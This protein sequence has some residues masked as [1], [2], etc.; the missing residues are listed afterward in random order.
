MGSPHLPGTSKGRA[1][2]LALAV[3]VAIMLVEAL[4]GL[5][6]GSLALLADAG[7]ML[8]DAAALGVS[9]FAVWIAR[10]PPDRART[11][12]YHRAEVLAALANGA[13]LWLLIGVLLHAAVARLLAPP[14]VKGLPMLVIALIGLAANLGCLAFLSGHG[15][16]DLNIRGAYLHVLSDALGSVGAVLA[17]A[18]LLTTGWRYADPLVSLAIGVLM[19]QSSWGL[20][21]DSVHILLEG[22]PPRLELEKVRAALLELDGVSEVH[23]LHLWCLSSGTE[24]MTGHLVVREGADAQKLLAD[25]AEMLGRRFALHHVTLQ[26]ESAKG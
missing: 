20:I 13:G 4:G 23:D 22:T 25:G 18:A 21:R 17:A 12:G 7:H 19:A 11:F 26:I 9:L 2:G 3:T 8:T 6:T 10:L 15:H 24:S 1:L 5:W 16:E 14:E